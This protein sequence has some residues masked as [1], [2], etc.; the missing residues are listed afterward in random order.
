[1]PTLA[2]GLVLFLGI[3]L[4]PTVPSARDALAARLGDRRYRGAF[5]LVVLAGLALIVVGYR[6]AEPGAQ[7]FAPLPLAVAA[8]PVAMTVAFILFA[9]ANMRTHLRRA[10]GHPMLLGTAIWAGV[11]LLAN[12]DARGT[13]LFGAFLVYALVDL[14]SAIRRHA[15]K[16]FEPAARQDVIAIV[17]GVAIALAVMTFHR[18]LFGHAV[19]SF[20]V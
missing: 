1:M 5:S 10:V 2:L 8:A 18:V 20:G 15:V 17:A 14:A 19:V 13:L 6:S 4:L 16:E 7:L 3:H 11:H 12:G 9:A